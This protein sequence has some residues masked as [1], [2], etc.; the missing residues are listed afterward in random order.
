MRFQETN[1]F[2]SNLVVDTSH[3]PVDVL[4]RFQESKN[5]V[6]A[7][8]SLFTLIPAS[9]SWGH[10]NILLFLINI[11]CC[12][13][14]SAYWSTWR[15]NHPLRYPDIAGSASVVLASG[16]ASY[17]KHP[18]PASAMVWWAMAI[19]Q[20]FFWYYMSLDALNN[21]TTANK[22]LHELHYHINFRAPMMF[23]TIFAVSETTWSEFLFYG[24]CGVVAVHMVVFYALDMSVVHYSAFL[25]VGFP[26]LYIIGAIAYIALYFHLF[27]PASYEPKHAG[28]SNF[29]FYFQIGLGVIL[30]IVGI[31]FVLFRY[32]SL[33]Q[34][35]KSGASK[36]K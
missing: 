8:T 33:M 10:G 14:A 29:S 27:G 23:V 11:Y 31:H 5:T 24:I 6:L 28:S 3:I 7:W 20:V 35:N 16:Y 34:S 36:S 1:P 26:Q 19:C 25:T 32:F 21:W 9:L 15:K 4:N 18:D 13:M 2:F 17:I 22:H 30:G 12:L